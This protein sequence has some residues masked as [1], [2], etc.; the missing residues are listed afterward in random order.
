MVA[1]GLVAAFWGR[2]EPSRD[3]GTKPRVNSVSRFA[4]ANPLWS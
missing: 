4:G 1:T 2:G 3:L